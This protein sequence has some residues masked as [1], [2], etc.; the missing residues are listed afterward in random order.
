ERDGIVSCDVEGSINNLCKLVLS[1]MRQTD[2]EI[3][4]IMT[5]K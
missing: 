5:R 1:P 2:K 4:S 3:I